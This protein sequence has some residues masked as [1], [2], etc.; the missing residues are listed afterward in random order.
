MSA[1]P[2]PDYDDDLKFSVWD[3]KKGSLPPGDLA[4][5]L[6]ALQ[7]KHDGVDWKQFDADWPKAFKTAAELDDA[8]AK[9]DRIYR[10]SAFPLKRDALAIAKLAKAAEKGA[11][12]PVLDAA[13]A[14]GKAANAYADA[15]DAGIDELKSL[16]DKANAALSKG[17]AEE[18]DEDDDEPGNVLL[19]PKRLL[20]MLT[21]C[22]RDPELSMN[23]AFVDGKDKQPAVFAMHPRMSGKK[24]FTVLQIETGVKTGSFGSA[25]IQV[26]G[27]FPG[28]CLMLQLDKPLSGLVKK[29]KAPVKAA[30]FKIARAVLWNSDG[31]VFEQES[32][33]DETAAPGA[34]TAGSPQATP[35]HKALSDAFKERLKTVLALAREAGDAEAATQAKKL[36]AEA[37]MHSGTRD[38]A[39]VDA[40]M[41]QAEGLLRAGKVAEPS[42]ST[43]GTPNDTGADAG[44]EPAT[45]WKTKV[46]QWTPAIKAAMAA[47]GPDAAA[48]AR[49][50]AQATSLSKQG[51]DMASAL[52]KLTECHELALAAATTTAATTAT[53]EPSE[54]ANAAAF[55]ARL[56]ALMP[57]VKET[58]VA[59]GP[60]ANDVK[61]K[62]S[63]AGVSARK[64]EFAQANAL[65]DE[66]DE[67]LQASGAVAAGGTRLQ[68]ED[69][70][71]KE[72]EG[73][74]LYARLQP[75]FEA[76]ER[77]PL[78]PA[79]AEQFQPIRTA[80][81]LAVEAIENAQFDRASL[82]LKRI[83]S[84]GGLARLLQAMT[85]E[86]K[87]PRARGAASGGAVAI[88]KLRLKWNAARMARQTAID[89]MISVASALLETEEYVDDPRTDAAATKI[90]DMSAQVPV[91][92]EKL[93]GLLD[94]FAEAADQGERDELRTR[95]RASIQAYRGK[96]D[97]QPLLMALQ[98]T[99]LGFTPIGETIYN[100]LTALDAALA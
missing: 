50:Y 23:F 77:G 36:C 26:N 38:W 34:R 54:T 82:I 7:K 99:P 55:N 27:E 8:F 49:L 16:H 76:V 59:A 44:S 88:A 84:A 12:K 2:Y 65:L 45:Q 68:E 37:G 25:W 29:V 20:A 98:N 4:D 46:A 69:I 80:W 91:L 93:S 83:D 73:A 52:A 15:V 9:R 19:E 40:L 87:Q 97:D 17:A 35:D 67:M 51:G 75:D 41:T 86:A 60:N 100:A 47:R 53:A 21:R 85:A 39:R 89:S 74:E 1:N 94:D 22:K 3:K 57:K 58:L 63:Q 11:A 62:V 90:R 32:E 18:G 72:R 43:G 42:A 31:T 10:S 96:L 71:P 61:L 66:V 28:T 70:D 33:S 79:L 95:I 64:K 56:A 5:D 6:K 81:M 24:L 13:K 48:M 78:S 14:I 92:D 30:G